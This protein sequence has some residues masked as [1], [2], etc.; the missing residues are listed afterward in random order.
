MAQGEQEHMRAD[1][2]GSPA[3]RNG[4][5]LF[6]FAYLL[7]LTCLY[8]VLRVVD[9]LIKPHAESSGNSNHERRLVSRN[10]N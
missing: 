9:M 1:V 8:N 6:R 5:A 2:N 10:T 7:S 4:M 3:M